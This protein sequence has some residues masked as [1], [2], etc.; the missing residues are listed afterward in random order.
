VTISLIAAIA[1]NG[2]IGRG[3]KLPWRL[4]DDMARFKALTLG[5]TVIMGR[6]TF[7]SLARPLAG[8]CN[9]VMSRDRGRKIEGCIV[10]GSLEEA[11]RA[12]A[13]PGPGMEGEG[14]RTG[15]VF[16]IGGAAVY[17]QFLPEARRMYLTWIDSDVDGDAT[18]PAVDW[19]QWR[20][21]NETRGGVGTAL[22][23]RFVDYERAG[24]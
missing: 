16:V 8:R 18:F 24:G 13:E 5:H 12:A 21:T 10:A 11:R 19:S 9:I 23:H 14:A 15:E 6:S 7:E 17:E 20:V 3:G 2:V 4:T 22:P 1:S